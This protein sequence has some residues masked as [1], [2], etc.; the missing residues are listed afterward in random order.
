MLSVLR[1]LLCA[2]TGLRL[3]P[4]LGL[5]LAGCATGDIAMLAEISGGE[6]VRVPFTRGGPEMKQEDG[7]QIAQAGITLAAEKKVQYIFAFTDSRNRALRR[8]LV[9]D[10][11]DAAA[12]PLVDDAQPKLSGKGEW[13]G[14]VPASDWS[15]ARVRWLATISNSLR[16]FRFSLTFADGRTLVLYQGA[17]YP[18]PMKAAVRQTMG[19]NY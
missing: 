1:P 10:V 5:V 3:A 18:A 8:V 12:V 14:E 11:S 16:V 15:D 13:K 19:Q 4:L 6:K 17:F 9:E 2:H 7:V